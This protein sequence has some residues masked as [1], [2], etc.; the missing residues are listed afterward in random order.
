MKQRLRRLVG[1]EVYS[2]SARIYGGSLELVR[3]ARWRHS[4]LNRRSREAL[5]KMRDRYAGRRCFVIGNG[6]SLKKLDL[7][8]LK[9]EI[10]IGSNG[11]FLIFK[12]MDF[13]PTFYTIEDRLVAADRFREA[14]AIAGAVK[15]YPRDLQRILGDSPDTVWLNFRRAYFNFPKFSEDLP[16]VCYW[17]GTVTHMNLQL[18]FWLGCSEIYMIGFD[19]NYIVPGD[20]SVQGAIITSQS[21]DP[22]HFHPDY[23]GKGYRWHDPQVERMERSYIV[24]RTHFE[25]AGRKVFNATAG[26]HLEVFPRRDY[27]ELFQ[28]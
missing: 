3:A 14:H 7:T 15:V 8:K 26:G 4:A 22:N 6:P 19:H 9:D 24:A 23:F 5:K 11:L 18:A 17:G 21:D 16:K 20:A 27:R 25:R 10:T 1:D 13:V 2:F 28:F 12:E